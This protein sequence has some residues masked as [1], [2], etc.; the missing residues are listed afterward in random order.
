MLFRTDPARRA[1]G[2]VLTLLG[3]IV[4]TIGGRGYLIEAPVRPGWILAGIM[5]IVAGTS[6]IRWARRARPD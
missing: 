2:W 3:F 1:A 4:L 6:L 5:W